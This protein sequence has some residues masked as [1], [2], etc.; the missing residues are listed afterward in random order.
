MCNLHGNEVEDSVSSGAVPEKQIL[1][2]DDHPDTLDVLSRLLRSLGYGVKRASTMQEALKAAVGIQLD[3]LIS[4]MTLPD[5]DGAELARQ[6]C[7]GRNI[8]AIALSGYSPGD[9]EKRCEGDE[10]QARLVKPIDFQVLQETIRKV[11]P[12]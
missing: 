10:F 7:A 1:V 4:D 3:L 9:E 12:E 5:G 6:L 2:V 11:L 8:P